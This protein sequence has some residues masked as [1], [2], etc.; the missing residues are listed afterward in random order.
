MGMRRQLT[1]CLGL[2]FKEAG[3]QRWD[4]QR[5]HAHSRSSTL[6]STV[7]ESPQSEQ[8]TRTGAFDSKV[9]TTVNR[10]PSIAHSC[11]TADTISVVTPIPTP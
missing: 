4:P 9:V 10:W 7:Q 3:S 2:P 11:Q 5:G 8:M 6:R 1:H